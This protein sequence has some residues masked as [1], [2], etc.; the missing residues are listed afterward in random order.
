MQRR[1]RA[2][3]CRGLYGPS[4]RLAWHYVC[5]AAGSGP[6]ARPVLPTFGLLA[7]IG[8]PDENSH[9]GPMWIYW[10]G[11]GGDGHPPGPWREDVASPWQQGRLA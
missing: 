7:G 8:Q 9:I 3:L 6:E 10:E 11:L 4:R 2:D 5:A 1:L